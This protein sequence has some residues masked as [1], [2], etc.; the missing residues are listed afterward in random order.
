MQFKIRFE[1]PDVDSRLA[2]LGLKAGVL[3]ESVMQGMLARSEATPN[4]PPL[5]AGFAA[6][7][8]RATLE[9]LSGMFAL[10]LWDR[11]RQTLTLARACR[12]AL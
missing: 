1:T 2:E 3:K 7:G 4:D 8:I 6:W 12:A 5:F 9:R 11:E 10:A